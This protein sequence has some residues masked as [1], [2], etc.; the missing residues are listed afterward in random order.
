[1]HAGIRNNVSFLSVLVKIPFKLNNLQCLVK[2]QI[3]INFRTIITL[4]HEN[5]FEK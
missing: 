3:Y 2:F 5:K 4:S 1:M